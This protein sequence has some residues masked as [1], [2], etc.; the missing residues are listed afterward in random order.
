MSLKFEFDSIAAEGKAKAIV[1][2]RYSG[3]L[4]YR[5]TFDLNSATRR[6]RFAQAVADRTDVPVSEIEPRLL[7]IS[8][9]QGPKI[10]VAEQSPELAPSD[11]HR[12]AAACLEHWR[13]ENEQ[14]GLYYW[15]GEYHVY[16]GLAY[17]PVSKEEV[18]AT[19]T[20]LIRREFDRLAAAGTVDRNSYP[21]RVTAHV[22]RDVLQAIA[23]IVRISDGAEQPAWLD[24]R[25]P[26]PL[27][28]L[29]STRG[30][31][32]D[33][34][35]YAAGQPVESYLHHSTPQFFTANGLEYAFDPAASCP[36][37][38]DFLLDIWG[39]DR[40]SIELL[41]EWFGYSLVPDTSQ[42]KILMLL[43]PKRSGKGTIAR[44]LRRLVGEAN[45]AGPTLA[46]LRTQFGLSPLLGKTLAI[47][48][49]ARISAKSNVSTIV[50]RLLSI[51]GEDAITVD[52]K[53]K[54]AVT[55]KL[56]ARIMI[57]TNE[58]PGLP[59]Q[60][61]A[62]SCRFLILRLCKSWYGREDTCLTDRLCDELPGILNWAV[63][64][65]AR[66]RKRGRFVQPER[67]MELVRNLERLASPIRAFLEDRCD[68]GDD[69][70][71]EKREMWEEWKEWC[72]LNGLAPGS[73]PI[74]GRDLHAAIPGLRTER[75]QN[76]GTKRPRWYVGVRLACPSECPEPNPEEP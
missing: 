57:L 16:D 31:L 45:V 9:Q 13:E 62:L 21:F 24:G 65:L 54:Q 72:D 10:A 70:R 50:E 11:P 39:S 6:K 48:S 38:I 37:W 76:G 12:L 42:Q 18:R 40:E 71:V 53:Y 75:P 3:E 68:L 73:E 46:S 23:S 64:G 66:L 52:R 59:D 74:L 22:V 34:A 60:S 2:A 47:V 5:D 33:V 4:L 20:K 55:T 1:T 36:Q 14:L 41:Q 69:C 26:A 63:K 67:S 7:A 35:A 19:V 15:R 51:S 17:R 28:Q 49:D 27:Q 43:G 30:G 56:N 29:L 32:V 44:V 61:N 58:L 25:P 8:D